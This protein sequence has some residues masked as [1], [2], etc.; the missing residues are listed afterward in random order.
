MFLKLEVKTLPCENLRG[1]EEEPCLTRR[2]GQ[3]DVPSDE[4]ANAPTQFVTTP[5]FIMTYS[6]ETVPVLCGIK[7]W[8]VPSFD[9][10]ILKGW[11]DSCN[12]LHGKHCVG[13]EDENGK[14]PTGFRVIDTHGMRITQP[15]GFVRYVALSYMWLA[16]SGSNIQLEKSNVN[17]LEMEDSLRTLPIPDVIADAIALCRDLG[18]RFLWVDRLCI[19]QDDQ[20]NKPGQINAMDKI[21]HLATFAIIAALNTRDGVGLPGFVNRPRHPRS[22]VWAPPHAGD[23]EAQGFDASVIIGNVVDTSLWNMRG[24]TFQER[25]LSK[26]RLF[27]TEYQ[28]IYECCEGQ[29]TELLTWNGSRAYEYESPR[30]LNNP[31]QRSDSPLDQDQQTSDLRHVDD[32]LGFYTENEY[33]G[34]SYVVKESA[35]IRDYCVWVKDY[36]SRQLSFGTDILNAFA[37]VGNALG[38]AL[39]S[40]MLYGLPEKYLTQ[41]LLWSTS[42]V[43]PRGETHDTPSWS[44]ASWL[45]PVR[46]DWHCGDRDKYFLKIASLVYF[47]YQD[48]DLQRLRKL[49]IEEM[50]IQNGT[51]IEEISKRDELPVLTG[52]HIPGEWRSN[53]DWRDCPQN[54]WQA[55]ERR[56]LNQ[57]ACMAAVMFPGS[58]VFN[59][60]VASLSIDHL[61]HVDNIPIKYEVS[62]ASLRNKSGE[63]VGILS[64]VEYGWVEARRGSDGN[65]KLFDFIVISGELEKYSVRK[66]Y[67]FFKMW[68]E[69]WLLNVML[70]HR[71]PCKPFVARRVAVGTVKPYKWKGCDPRW[72]TVVLC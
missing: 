67:S 56:S 46:Y 30:E 51:S 1:G 41:C 10:Q 49:D 32:V 25:L 61:R 15:D 50:W 59:T 66:N 44:W 40:Q 24:W 16:G 65:K 37:G 28:V 70:V 14:L 39:G 68:D 47:Y 3:V 8:E 9:V 13:K 45:N 26:R 55:F 34:N 69:M 54:P 5:Q 62:N 63:A 7:E 22:S 38:I 42:S 52:K 35:S 27:I 72:E 48:P 12:K 19:V 71:L 31:T 57:D 23:V 6:K 11:L 29:A 17:A 18:E 60:T 36:S 53:R 64:E 21:Y 4:V 43:A 20:Y 2:V 33:V 58:L